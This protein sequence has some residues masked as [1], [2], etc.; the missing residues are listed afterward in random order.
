MAYKNNSASNFNFDTTVT[1]DGIEY[2]LLNLNSPI[3]FENESGH[4]DIQVSRSVSTDTALDTTVDGTASEPTEVDNSLNSSVSV[5][6]TGVT[7]GTEPTSGVAAPVTTSDETIETSEPT[8]GSDAD[9]L[10]ST[11]DE[12]VSD[13]ETTLGDD[14]ETVT[15]DHTSNHSQPIV[16]DADVT[17]TVTETPESSVPVVD[18]ETTVAAGADAA[19]T[20]KTTKVPETTVA[21]QPATDYVTSVEADDTSSEVTAGPEEVDAD[22]D[23]DTADADL[24]A[25]EDG[26]HDFGHQLASWLADLDTLVFDTEAGTTNLDV[27]ALLPQYADAVADV[28]GELQTCLA[29]HE[30]TANPVAAEAVSDYLAGIQAK[31]ASASDLLI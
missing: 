16:A 29:S 11:S 30:A 22:L 13:P 21:E 10:V 19:T 1:I 25:S 3:S 27:D 23:S 6:N 7:K 4:W 9:P 24:T 20:G 17:S 15:A 18:D 12:T 14:T 8:V 2:D 26:S 31:I 5:E 28:L